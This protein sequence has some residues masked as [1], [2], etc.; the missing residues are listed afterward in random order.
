MLSSQDGKGDKSDVNTW[1]KSYNYQKNLDDNRDRNTP[2]RA[3]LAK[4]YNFGMPSS[5]ALNYSKSAS[6]LTISPTVK[7]FYSFIIINL[8]KAS[9]YLNKNIDLMTFNIF[10]YKKMSENQELS[11]M[12]LFLFER[13]HF[14][15]TLNI[16]QETFIRFSKKVQDGYHS[17][18]YHNASHGADVLQVFLFIINFS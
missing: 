10:D 11:T 4:K 5:M 17:N 7:N 8:K 14:F 12:M 15:D 18:A 16:K 13:H 9:E 6:S 1:L 2:G 3:S